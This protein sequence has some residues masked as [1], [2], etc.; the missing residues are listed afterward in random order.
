ELLAHTGAPPGRRLGAVTL[1]G[2]LRGLLLDASERY[3]LE[4]RPLASATAERLSPILTVGSLVGNP[5]DGGFS[6]VS[7]A[8]NFMASIAALDADPNTDIVLV[9]ETLPRAPGSERAERYIL[10]ANEYAAVKAKKPIA[11]ITPI[12]RGQNDYS[13]ALRAKAPHVS[14]LEEA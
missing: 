2:A 13:R 8:E 1:S 9:Q 7:S 10:L 12:S 3:G 4:F 14:F 5:I 6:V 11:F